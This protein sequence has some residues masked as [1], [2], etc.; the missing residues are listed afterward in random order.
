MDI[1][2]VSTFLAIMNNA[3]M[4]IDVQIFA[5]TYIFISLMYIP[6]GGIARLYSSPMY[7]LWGNC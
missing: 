5:W 6:R 2:V 3:T 7:N 1:W 4:N